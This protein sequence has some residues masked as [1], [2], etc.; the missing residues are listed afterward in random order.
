M[1]QENLM[2]KMKFSLVYDMLKRCFLMFDND[3]EDTL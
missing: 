2:E 3:K 1:H